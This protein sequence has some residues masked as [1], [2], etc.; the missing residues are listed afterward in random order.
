LKV[1]VKLFAQFRHITD[2]SEVEIDVKGKT[3]QEA[4]SALLSSY[5]ALAPVVMTDHEIKPYV[6]LMLNGRSVKDR[7]G[8]AT[9]LKEGDTLVL[10]PTMAG[11]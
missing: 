3:V 5:P 10:F 6:N 1:R 11:G 4:L 9:V 2:N 8:M 7:S